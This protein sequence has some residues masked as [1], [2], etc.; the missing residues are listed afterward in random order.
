MTAPTERPTLVLGHRCA[1]CEAPAP[2]PSLHD[3]AMCYAC[4]VS[5]LADA[6]ADADRWFAERDAL[7]EQVKTLRRVLTHEIAVRVNI[8]R[9]SPDDIRIVEAR[10]ALASTE[11][12][13]QP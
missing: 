11:T 4:A 10:A 6:Q 12:E 7:R 2:E 8:F 9:Y 1:V 5:S 3:E 13:V